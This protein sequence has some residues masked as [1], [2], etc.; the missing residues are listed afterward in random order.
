M[1]VDNYRTIA[2]QNKYIEKGEE[3][4][5]AMPCYEYHE[6]KFRASFKRHLANPNGNVSCWHFKLILKGA[7]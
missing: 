7:C 3:D 6:R 2:Q 1:F 4:C 5:N